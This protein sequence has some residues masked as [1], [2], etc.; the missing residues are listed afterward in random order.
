MT[1][2]KNQKVEKESSKDEIDLLEEKIK[3]IKI[4]TKFG[5]KVGLR[6]YL[7]SLEEKV[8]QLSGQIGYLKKKSKR[9]N[10]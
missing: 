8:I 10:D 4:T 1:E 5:K 7:N 3:N 6:E 9:R 2:N